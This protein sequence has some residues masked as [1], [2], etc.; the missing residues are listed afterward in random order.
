M[1]NRVWA[2]AYRTTVVCV[3]AYDEGVLKGRLYNPSSP[4]GECFHS[5]MDFLLK[6]EAL[7]DRMN[8]PQPFAEVRAFSSK[9]VPTTASPPQEEMHEGKRATF[10]LRVL[11]R[12]NAS[13]QGSVSWLEG[14]QEESFRSVLELLILM[15]SALSAG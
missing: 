10:A 9:T 11:F 7:L 8:F 1:Q 13:W 6:M 3:D 2:N 4:D 14:G 5:L 15:N 12:Q